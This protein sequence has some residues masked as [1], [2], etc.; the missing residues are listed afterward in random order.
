MG[1]VDAFSADRTVEVK[2][3]ELEG[4]LKNAGILQAENR[5]LKNGLRN[6]V[7]AKYIFKMLDEYNEE[8]QNNA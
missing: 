2:V 5:C 8:A 3:I 6:G 4:L 7:P 1:L